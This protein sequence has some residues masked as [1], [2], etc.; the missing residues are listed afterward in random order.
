M[1]R[2]VFHLPRS[3]N[4]SLGTWVEKPGY[5]GAFLRRPKTASVFLLLSLS[6]LP[7][8][9]HGAQKKGPPPPNPF[10]LGWWPVKK[11]RARATIKNPCTPHPD[12]FCSQNRPRRKDTTP[13]I[14]SLLKSTALKNP[15]QTLTPTKTKPAFVA[16][17]MSAVEFGCRR[18]PRPWMS[19]AW[20]CGP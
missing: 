3:A 20:R 13:W 9:G 15:P 2:L 8:R 6:N 10:L 16:S 18:R 11:K 1:I 14:G 4:P 17:L 7:R 19:R 5:L 12:S